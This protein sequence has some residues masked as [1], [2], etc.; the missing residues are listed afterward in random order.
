MEGIFLA[1]QLRP[2]RKGAGPKRNPI[3]VVLS[4]YAYTIWRR[5]T[6]FDVVIHVGGGEGVYLVVNH[7][8]HHKRVSADRNFGV[9]LCLCLHPLKQNGLIRHGNTYE[10]Q[11]V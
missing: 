8:S 7:A 5:I 9:L 4:I 3:F 2:Y 1:G 10:E 11:R 6:K